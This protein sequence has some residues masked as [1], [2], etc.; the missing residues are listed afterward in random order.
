[1][2]N[3]SGLREN[4]IEHTKSFHFLHITLKTESLLFIN[5][6]ENSWF[7]AFNICMLSYDN[8]L[9]NRKINL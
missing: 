9:K 4:I 5:L 7:S 3:F 1:M 6:L 8:D 2:I